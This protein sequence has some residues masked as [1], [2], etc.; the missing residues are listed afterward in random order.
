MVANDKPFYF[1]SVFA[2]KL[3]RIKQRDRADARAPRGKRLEK[4]GA[5]EPNGTDHT[6]AGNKNAPTT[7]AIWPAI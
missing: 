3:L 1:R 2:T 5:T 7:T 6:N 4:L